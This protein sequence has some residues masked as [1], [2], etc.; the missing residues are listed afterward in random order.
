MPWVPALGIGLDMAMDGLGLLLVLLTFVLGL[1]AVATAWHELRHPGF[2]HLCLLWT[3]AGVVGVF[4]AL[5]L[6]LFY[7]FWELMLIP[8]FFLIAIWGHENRVYASIK[9]FIFTQVSGLLMLA[10]I[11]GIFLFTAMRP[12]I[13]PSIFRS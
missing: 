12:A 1:A 5:D 11:L 7:F 4:L 8:M 2:F 9:F 13:S 10:S 6:V 3:L